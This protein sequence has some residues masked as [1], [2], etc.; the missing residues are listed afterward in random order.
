MSSPEGRH[1]TKRPASP[2]EVSE[3]VNTVNDPQKKATSFLDEASI[4][5]ACLL[6]SELYL[7][8]WPRSFF[9]PGRSLL[10]IQVG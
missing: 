3:T 9:G 1:G 5:L 6:T 8:T 7:E 10:M 2:S 4:V